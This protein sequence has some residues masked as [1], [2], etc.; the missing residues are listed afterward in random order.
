MNKS[1]A[2]ALLLALPLIGCVQA[3]STTPS[4]SEI[5]P[6]TLGLGSEAAPPAAADWWKAFNDPQLDRLV[7]QLLAKNPTL[8]GALARIR[9]AEAEVS[10]AR[11]LQYPNINIDGT[12]TVQLVSKDFVYPQRFGGTWQWVGDVEARLRWSLDFWGRQAALIERARNVR[13]A[14]SL[15]ANAARL[16]LAGQFAQSYVALL[17][18]WQNIDIAHQT[19]EER[20]TILELTQSRVT[21]G[22][23]NEA[24]LEQA[25]ALM[26]MAGMELRHTE[27]QR[28]IGVHAIAAL[29]G[30]GADA[31]PS[32]ARPAVAV[33]NALPLPEH[34]PADLLSRRPDI[35]AAQIRV[36]AASA[37]RE[38]AHADFYPNIDLTAALGFQAI[39][40]SNLFSSDA[41]TAG[42]GPA[43]HLPIF[44][45]GRIRAQ[46][47]RAT[48]DLDAAVADYNGTVV[49]AVRQ[50]ADALTEVASLADQRR[51]Q[52]QALDS[53][54]RAFDLAK[55]RYRLGL[56]GQIPMLTAEA[57][58]LEAR[59]Q[60]A[61]LVAEAANQRVAL[62]LAAGG[63]YNPAR[64][65]S[66]SS[67]RLSA[68]PKQDATP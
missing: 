61:A 4:Q 62:L 39:G 16:A 33:E 68:N 24:S 6:A 17:L 31:Y 2:A 30:R 51:Q 28:D 58:L 42:V 50:T 32:I 37:G 54:E 49:R 47:A 13:E 38:A 60:M 15:D 29:I 1:L 34:L 19:L 35:L 23:E 27:A 10:S 52:K 18:A 48:A 66:I 36:S 9:A 11:S 40:F 45:A 59:R 21:S 5:V 46:Y 67:A 53:A 55:E 57:T 26:A 56:S 8:Q 63:G 22:L 7:E 44:D 25:K 12:D 43:I 41:L 14:A 3:P 65:D 64:S 20:Q